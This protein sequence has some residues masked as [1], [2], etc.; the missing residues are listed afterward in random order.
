MLSSASQAA[1]CS[2]INTQ[3]MCLDCSYFIHTKLFS[4]GC[5]YICYLDKYKPV[6]LRLCSYMYHMCQRHAWLVRIF[7]LSLAFLRK[8]LPH[9]YIY[10]AFLCAMY[11]ISKS[12]VFCCVEHT[13]CWNFCSLVALPTDF[14]VVNFL[15]STP[16][17]FIRSWP[18]NSSFWERLPS[19]TV[20]HR[21]S[22]HRLKPFI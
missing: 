3:A 17:S 10:S 11:K 5:S 9:Q 13:C 4:R 19:C 2:S 16:H 18:K 12:K 14:L 22:C 1:I 15:L 20:A 6:T 21:L 7:L 8:S